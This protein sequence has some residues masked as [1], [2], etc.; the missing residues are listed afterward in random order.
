MYN[1]YPY[2]DFSELNLDWFLEQFKELMENWGAQKVDY[3][4][5]KLDVTT[6][7]N[8]LSG[9]FDDLKDAFNDLYDYVHDYFDNLDVQQEINNKLDEMVSDGTMTAL[10]QP[11]F[12]TYK[13][14]IDDEVEDQN[15][16]IEVLEGRMD[17]FSALVDGSTTGDA[18][19][20]DIRVASNGWT[21]PTAGDAVRAMDDILSGQTHYLMK[22][23]YGMLGKGERIK[24][25]TILFTSADVN[26]GD[27]IHWSLTTINAANVVSYIG[28]YDAND[29]RLSY[30]GKG[31]SGSAPG[32][33]SG[34]DM[35]IPEGFSYAKATTQTAQYFTLDYLIDTAESKID[36][37]DKYSQSEGCLYLDTVF[38]TGKVLFTSLDVAGGS[39]LKYDFTVSN[40]TIG[41]IGFYNSSDT[42]IASVG[43]TSSGSTVYD[44][45]GTIQIPST[46]SYA[47]LYTHIAGRTVT[48]KELSIV[49]GFEQYVEENLDRLDPY[50][51]YVMKDTTDTTLGY[52]HQAFPSICY[53]N[54]KE[55]ICSRVSVSHNTP[56][57]SA[58]WGGLTFD[59]R[60]LSGNWSRNVKTLNK[61]D[62]IGLDGELRDPQIQP[63]RDGQYLILATWTTYYDSDNNTIHDNVLA[64]LDANLDVVAYKVDK[65][66][67][68]LYWGNPLITPSGKLIITAYFPG[69]TKL[70]ISDTVLNALNLPT[71]TF[72]SMTL[73]SG[74]G[75]PSEACIGY[76][77][78]YLVCFIRQD[79]AHE[80]LFTK[81][82]NPEGTS[83]WEVVR[84]IG[85]NIHAPKVLPY[86]SGN[87]LPFY[88]AIMNAG[89]TQRSPY[90]GYFDVNS[91]T[92]K[93]SKIVD[94]LV[95]S[96]GYGGFIPVADQEYDLI[97]YKEGTNTAMYFER[98][99]ARA[100][101]PASCYYV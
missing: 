77:N 43:R 41:Y 90:F 68:Y 24:N 92:I 4:Q 37:F 31:T 34:I 6:E 42:L 36:K 29:V 13:A 28:L 97:Y 95:L 72:T 88:G 49:S 64:L 82:S 85:E 9:K 22:D 32:T 55:I 98:I 10:I 26:V 63:T 14:Q 74:S 66:A 84:L 12:D 83:G 56:S 1:K 75:Q 52:N 51:K 53:F 30:Y 19:L 81:T 60:D 91:A 40:T 27:F 86:A 65:A 48:I 2:T 17:T 69:T 96:G 20:Q 80:T 18:E 59:T 87:V 15:D 78:N 16:R 33:F 25:N 57:N 101:I 8:T 21:Y 35:Y 76:F 44:Y 50:K 94:S 54:N 89:M 93:A 45:S 11:L 3:N 71:M 46:Y 5:F 100:L 23:G 47:K 61:D 62:F 73:S 79:N 7:F 39:V 38:T 67:P 70:Y 99:N 58:Q